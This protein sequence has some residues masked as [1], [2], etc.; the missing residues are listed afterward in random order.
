[1]TNI[2]EEVKNATTTDYIGQSFDFENYPGL[3]FV[4]V[5][6]GLTSLWL[7]Y[8]T[9]YHSRL[10]AIIITKILNK[11]YIKDGSIYIGKIL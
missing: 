11:F 7:F 3:V 8:I 10:V 2:T 1:M 5:A 4:S 6:C 9:F